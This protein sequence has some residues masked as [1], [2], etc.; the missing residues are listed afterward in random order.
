M[1]QTSFQCIGLGIIFV[2]VL[3]GIAC[4]FINTYWWRRLLVVRN[5]FGRSICKGDVFVRQVH[6]GGFSKECNPPFYRVCR[7]CFI[8]LPKEIE[9]EKEVLVYQGKTLRYTLESHI[10]KTSETTIYWDWENT[11]KYQSEEIV[12]IE[13][14]RYTAFSK[15]L[16][17][18]GENKNN[19]NNA[20]AYHKQ[21]KTY[22]TFS[23]SCQVCLESFLNGEEV[24]ML[25]C[26]HGFHKQ[27]IVSCFLA[28]HMNCPVCN[29]DI[30]TMF[31]QFG[32]ESQLL[33]TEGTN[34][35][36]IGE[37]TDQ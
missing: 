2:A 37:L 9:L 25:K 6:H 34:Y 7:Y 21:S 31:V 3:F 8:L 19:H 13:G 16:E 1:D 5:Y 20:T 33:R 24:F 32:K 30:G 23:I 4:F 35:G 10:T 15:G 29:A 17:I 14:E 28:N 18:T 12:L 36:A 22:D 27:C 26:Y 11:E